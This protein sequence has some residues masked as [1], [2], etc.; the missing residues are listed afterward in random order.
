MFRNYVA[1]YV[2]ICLLAT[3][4]SSSYYLWLYSDDG[5]LIKNLVSL[6]RDTAMIIFAL[7]TVIIISYV[8]IL[9]KL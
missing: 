1:T 5:I 6:V 3:C 7:L 4:M 2:R 8:R 9:H